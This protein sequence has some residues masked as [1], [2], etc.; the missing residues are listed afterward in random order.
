MPERT[1][2]TLQAGA[3]VSLLELQRHPEGGWYRETWRHEGGQQERGA[4]TAIYYMLTEGE[5]SF[6]HC[7]DAAEIWHW[8]A[9]APLRLD[10]SASAGDLSQCLLGPDLMA[11]ERPQIIVPSGVWQSARS[12]GAWTLVGCTVSP[13][14]MFSGFEIA[15]AGWQPA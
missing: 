2:A 13:A 3:V 11:G 14:F 10:L 4:G 9:G 5:V 15:P 1:I 12:L 7:V 8:Y 6:W